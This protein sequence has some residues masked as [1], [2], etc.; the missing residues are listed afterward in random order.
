MTGSDGR[1][2]GRAVPIKMRL[3]LLGFAVAVWY[4]LEITCRICPDARYCVVVVHLHR[5]LT[6]LPGVVEMYVEACL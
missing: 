3:L 5:T 2:E 6:A 1:Q 4:A